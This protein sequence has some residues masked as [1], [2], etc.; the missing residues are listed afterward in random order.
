MDPYGSEYSKGRQ[1]RR[2]R[3][4]ERRRAAW[5][6]GSV[7]TELGVQRGL[8]SEREHDKLYR[9]T[10]MAVAD[11]LV[12]GRGRH[13]VVVALTSDPNDPHFSL[14]VKIVSKVFMPSKG[15]EP[16]FHRAVSHTLHVQNEVAA[17]AK[18]STVPT[19]VLPLYCAF[20]DDSYVYLVMERACCSLKQL[21]QHTDEQEESQLLAFQEAHPLK[22]LSFC[23]LTSVAMLH[24]CWTM[25]RAHLIHHDIHPAQVLVT[26]DGRPCLADLGQCSVIPAD[27]RKQLLPPLG[28]RDFCRPA[29]LGPLQGAEVDGYGCGATLWVVW[30]GCYN[31]GGRI[32]REW[33]RHEEREALQTRLEYLADK[34]A[35]TE[36]PPRWPFAALVLNHIKSTSPPRFASSVRELIEELV[37]A[38]QGDS[39]ATTTFSAESPFNQFMPFLRLTPS[40]AADPAIALEPT[41][42][43]LPALPREDPWPPPEGSMLQAIYDHACTQIHTMEL[44]Q[45]QQR[46]RSRAVRSELPELP[47]SLTAQPCVSMLLHPGRVITEAS[48]PILRV[49]LISMLVRDEIPAQIPIIVRARPWNSSASTL[50]ESSTD[51]AWGAVEG[52]ASSADEGRGL[53]LHNAGGGT[54]SADGYVVLAFSVARRTTHMHMA[55]AMCVS[56]CACCSM[57]RASCHIPPPSPSLPSS[58]LDEGRGLDLHNA[59]GGTDSADGYVVL[60]FSVAREEFV[61][62]GPSGPIE[63][64][65]SLL[66]SMIEYTRARLTFEIPPDIS[67]QLGFCATPPLLLDRRD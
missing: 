26:S 3:H 9:A 57:Y 1:R 37:T 56:T 20:Q 58:P 59:G 60:A 33:N 32:E 19:F 38:C 16:S 2:T 66:I 52:A 10:M 62:E 11:G 49:A 23:A 21:I 34:A 65:R 22:F 4:E 54:D 39:A 40:L 61:Q 36:T 42:F 51:A 24:A 14:A 17:M 18:L 27:G 31:G 8:D 25:Q 47:I 67:R 43:A 15:K 41:N 46:S 13:G 5:Q 44:A 53:D 50:P 45:Q 7:T 30:K 48:E 12:I 64:K 35:Q 29:R 63:A 55:H 28:R 6:Q